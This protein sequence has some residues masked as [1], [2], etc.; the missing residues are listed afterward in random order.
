MVVQIFGSHVFFLFSH[1][2]N[3]QMDNKSSSQ[4]ASAP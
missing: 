3:R 1:L 2:N 4:F